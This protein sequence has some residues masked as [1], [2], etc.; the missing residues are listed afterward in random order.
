MRETEGSGGFPGQEPSGHV[1]RRPSDPR[2]GHA[3]KLGYHVQTLPM[4]HESF[5]T[6]PEEDTECYG[7]LMAIEEIG[8]YQQTILKAFHPEVRQEFV[9]L[10]GGIKSNHEEMANR[11]LQDGVI[12]DEAWTNRFHSEWEGLCRVAGDLIGRENEVRPWYDLGW[13]L[14]KLSD[15]T[16]RSGA[17]LGV[18]LL[19]GGFDEIIHCSREISP[20]QSVQ[21]PLLQ[22]IVGLAPVLEGQGPVA[23]LQDL[24]Q[25]HF[26][27]Y[28]DL[29]EES[30]KYSSW[31]ILRLLFFEILENIGKL[32]QRKHEELGG[33]QKVR[34]VPWDEPATQR[35]KMIYEMCMDR[36]IYKKILDQV[37]QQ[38][39]KR[40]W[41]PIHSLS[42]VR[43][44]ALEYAK[45]NDLPVPPMRKNGK[46]VD[47]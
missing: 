22:S 12:P 42:R 21:S 35:N 37:N 27:R 11:F 23:F 33:A 45:W 6:L 30:V 14:G 4:W 40:G 39:Q 41:E 18:D 10:L 17:H 26:E 28:S 16:F 47:S 15:Q 31:N 36:I 46:P 34:R 44:I 2:P 25:K 7:V 9:K 29:G 19:L 3:F 32:T 8:Q 20:E 38:S 5:L 43:P 1:R 13:A 24:C